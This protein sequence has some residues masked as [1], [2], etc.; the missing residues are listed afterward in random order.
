MESLGVFADGE[1]DLLRILFSNDEPDQ[2]PFASSILEDR[3]NL[4]IPSTLVDNPDKALSGMDYLGGVHESLYCSSVS[5]LDSFNLQC[6]SQ[7]S[8]FSSACSNSFLNVP[9]PG[10]ENYGNSNYVS[11][12]SDQ[13]CMFMDV[14]GNGGKNDS[15]VTDQ[16][17]LCLRE[18][19]IGEAKFKDSDNV[20]SQEVSVPVEALP[21]KR[22]PSRSGKIASRSDKTDIEMP[23]KPKKK[24]R[25]SSDVQ[26]TRKKNTPLKRN[27]K[28]TSLDDDNEERNVKED[29]QSSS[30]C[31][32]EDDVSSHDL[33]DSKASESLSSDAKTR[34]SRGA[35]T[36][37][38]SLYARKRRERINERLK[39]LQNLI[40]NGTKVDISTMLEEAV[41]Y[42]KFL[43]LQ[44]KLLSS[45]N[46][47]MY[48]P[49]AYNGKDIGLD[50][51]LFPQL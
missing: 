8:S 37:P 41:Q 36:D 10:L 50:R 16:E 24:P 22:K 21:L 4:Q 39:I 38:Q 46:L 11:V 25:L 15:L 42:V 28:L 26:K 7:E 14:C 6:F 23:E 45:D 30:T 35:A 47:W 40:P 3:P 17:T 20:Q 31:S 43:Q 12:P 49:I 13:V 1:L 34:A 5:D 27:Q 2:Y 19:M 18:N 44:I 9:I 33:K 29:G 32:S 48:A 51:I